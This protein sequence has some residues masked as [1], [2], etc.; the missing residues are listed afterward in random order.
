MYFGSESSNFSGVL[1]LWMEDTREYDKDD[2]I[3][4]PYNYLTQNSGKRMRTKLIKAFNL[5]LK[6]DH[7][8]LELLSDIIETLHNSSLIID[9]IEDNSDKRRGKPAAHMLFGVPLSINAA[10]YAYFIALE[11]ALKLSH[12][13][14]PKIFTEQMIDL[15]RGQGMD[16][17]WRCSLKCPTEEEYKDMVIRKTGG[18]F[19]M[20]VKLM[21]LFS[22]TTSDFTSLLAAL[23]LWF[24]I[25]D[26]YSN[27]VD[28]T[29]HEAKDFADDLTEGKFSFP[30]V[31]AINS[32]PHDHQIMAILQQHTKD[33]AVKEH[34]IHHLNEL[35]S[36]EYTA[37]TLIQLERQCRE[38]VSDLGG[39]PYV[40]QF[41]DDY[42]KVYRDTDSW[43]PRL[44]PQIPLHKKRPAL[45]N[46]DVENSDV[47]SS[48]STGDN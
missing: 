21:Q 48:S 18:L 13:N 17:Y 45:T 44:Y 20:A 15:H 3:L 11:K 9:D 25:R 30:I 16:I 26:D 12:P 19:G 31:H 1:P 28:T 27:L 6:I 41:F 22:T 42:S 37:R 4:A 7:E 40:L 36:L 35:G 38:I 39:N 32:F 8:K 33:R 34:A 29:Y 5:W 46:G 24:Q 10:N 43:E 2:I 14:V 23:G 47:Y